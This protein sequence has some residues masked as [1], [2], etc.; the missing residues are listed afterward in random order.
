MARVGWRLQVALLAAPCLALTILLVRSTQIDLLVHNS[1]GTPRALRVGDQTLFLGPHG[2]A[3]L[4]DVPAGSLRLGAAPLGPDAQEEVE[5]APAVASLSGRRC[6]VWTVGGPTD[7]WILTKGYGDRSE[8]RYAPAR[9]RP[10]AALFALPSELLPALEPRF[11]EDVRVAK[12]ETG[13]V[14]RGLFTKRSLERYLEGRRGQPPGVEA[15][16]PSLEAPSGWPRRLIWA[17]LVGCLLLVVALLARRPWR[18]EASRP[19]LSSIRSSLVLVSAFLLAALLLVPLGHFAS[20]IPAEDQ[21]VYSIT[22]LDPHDE[23]GHAVFLPSLLLDGDVDVYNQDER[24]YYLRLETTPTGR[25]LQYWT[26]GTPLLWAPYYLT[27][28][29]GVSL[30]SACGAE[31]T[32]DGVGPPYLLALA[33]GSASFLLLGAFLCRRLARELGWS[34]RVALATSLALSFSSLVPY[35][36]FIRSRMD[37]AAEFFV[38]AAAAGAWLILRRTEGSRKAYAG[39]GLLWGLAVITRQGN[40]VLLA[41]PML[42]VGWRAWRATPSRRREI[43]VQGLWFGAGLALPALLHLTLL[44]T[45]WGVPFSAGHKGQLLWP[46]SAFGRLRE[47]AIGSWGVFLQTP[48]WL[49]GVAGLLRLLRDPR[50]RGLAALCLVQLVAASVVAFLFPED[51]LSAYG[52]RTLVGAQVFLLPG[53]ARVL[54]GLP[55]LLRWL[56]VS[57]LVGWQYL[58]VV[59]YPKLLDQGAERFVRDAAA[60]VPEVLGSGELLLRSTCLPKVLLRLSEATTLSGWDALWLIGV[61]LLFVVVPLLALAAQ[62]WVLRNQRRGQRLGILVAGI[63][64]VLELLLLAQVAPL[65]PRERAGRCLASARR[66]TA[67]PL[68]A[69]QDVSQERVSEW[70]ERAR[71]LD[72]EHPDLERS[73]HLIAALR[74]PSAALPELRRLADERGEDA[75]VAFALG[76][77]LQQQGDAPGAQRALAR[78]AALDPRH[79]RARIILAGIL[80]HAGQHAE[81]KRNL[82]EARR[83]AYHRPRLQ[84]ELSAKQAALPR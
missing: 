57:L 44:Q 50:R 41:G 58:Q 63:L 15:A 73:L 54:G 25:S 14:R 47:M 34:E 42:D 56:S 4:K 60:N 82:G 8:Q 30:A 74:R 31:V 69:L 84:L 36:A 70:L 21:L 6:Y 29:G 68:L 43:L 33:L 22:F 48:V 1:T 55:S 11:P 76:L 24:L 75:E 19:P 40:V 18:G 20:W 83:L 39:L 12:G 13:A 53:L 37:H 80:A 10:P 27:A 17:A 52:Y 49:L 65:S 23:G 67:D 62:T 26:L 64:L 3:E 32:P 46:E 66:A 72:P 51:R 7:Y 78:A 61:P 45:I 59:Q 2:V 77:A 79:L 16:S 38:V 81:A 71:E 5:Y 9:V 35:Y 28:H